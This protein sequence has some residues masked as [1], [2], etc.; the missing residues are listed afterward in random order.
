M[1]FLTI[2]SSL[3]IGF[4]CFANA[5]LGEYV[6]QFKQSF[7]PKSYKNLNFE[8]IENETYLIR[9]KS[10]TL[11]NEIYHDKAI[12]IIEPNYLYHN[13]SMVNDPDYSMQWGFKNTGQNDCFGYEGKPGI[14]IKLEEAWKIITG[15]R[16]VVIGVIDSGINYELND[17]RKNTWI[18]R[19]EQNGVANYDDD[20]NG[21][22]DDVFGYD[23]A[24]DRPVSL[25]DD[26]HGTHCAG[27]I[28]ARSNNHEGITGIMQN[29]R[30]M[31]L[32]YSQGETGYLSEAIKAINYAI[33]MKVDILNCSW[34]SEE[35]SRL[36]RRALKKA[37]KAGILVVAAAGNLGTNNDIRPVYPAS[38][39]LPNLISVAAIN[40]RGKLWRYSNYGIDTTHIA[41]PGDC[42][43][44][45]DM[46]GRYGNWSGTSMAA[47]FVAGVAGLMRAKNP[48]MT[49]EEIIQKMIRTATPLDSLKGKV[50][51]NGL[52][53][54]YQALK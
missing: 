49:P 50:K 6:V 44:S 48:Q 35:N 21:Y 28:G 20:G 52:L 12:A 26:G 4:E 36:L 51:S 17:L 1:K 5:A 14:D 37:S 45:Y 42:I 43:L 9:T 46:S 10:L 19:E 16:R 15:H 41:A 40:N 11:P 24:L 53:N 18:N 47:P 8:K 38:Y 39:K 30:L 3:I 32:K 29:V 34:G 31:S 33:K 23:F 2:L 13:F 27:T 7:N 25:D 54:A 22:K